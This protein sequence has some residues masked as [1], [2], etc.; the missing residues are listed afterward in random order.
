MVKCTKKQIRQLK[1]ALRWK[2]PAVQRQRIQMVLLPENG[3]TQP[4][5]AEAVGVS[6]SIVNRAHMAYD[7]GG[8][9]HSSRRHHQQICPLDDANSGMSH[10]EPPL[11]R[12][13]RQ[14]LNTL[15][16][17]NRSCRC[18]KYVRGWID[19]GSHNTFDGGA[20][21]RIDSS[22]A[23]A[24]TTSSQICP[25]DYIGLIC[26][27]VGLPSLDANVC[28]FFVERWRAKMRIPRLLPRLL[29]TGPPQCALSFRYLLQRTGPIILA[30]ARLLENRLPR[31]LHRPEGLL[32]AGNQTKATKEVSD[33]F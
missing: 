24:G 4:A 3:V 29:S 9:K 2:L 28:G 15:L 33:T 8:I 1:T 31:S 20:D 22:L 26:G 27:F 30:P 12:F 18:P 7:A 10:I 25:L 14:I 21:L 13:R 16:I 23:G 32:T 17:D 6:L 5:I 19:D 11:R